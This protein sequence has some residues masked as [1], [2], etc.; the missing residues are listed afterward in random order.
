ME[1]RTLLEMIND[2]MVSLDYETISNIGD[3]EESER[4]ARIIR[5]EYS[6]LMDRLDWPHVKVVD[7]LNGL[8]DV[9]QP[10]FMQVPSTLAQIDSIRYDVTETGDAGKTI[11]DVTFYEDP[12]DFLDLVYS[13]NTG[14]SNVSIYNTGDG[15]PIWT[16]T[17]TGPSFCTTFDDDTIIFDAYNSS[18]DTT[19]QASKSI[20][21]GLRGAS[22]TE[23]E[24]FTPSMPVDMFSLFVSKCK[25]VANEQL[26]QVTLATEARDS[27]ILLNRASHKRRVRNYNRK[28]NY[29][30]GR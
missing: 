4:V 25:V 18:E 19:L 9:T 8:G 23:D 7:Q 30:R 10:N 17:D 27:Q 28:P 24:S 20:V 6:K 3:T 26:R 15:I 22:W 13:R 14:D 11:Q 5:N 1:R 29:G 2:V 21:R 12:N 16:L